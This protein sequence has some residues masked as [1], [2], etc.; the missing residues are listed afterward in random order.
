MLK[1]AYA[2]WEGNRAAVLASSLA[3]LGAVTWL[4]YWTGTDFTFSVFYLIPILLVTW[5]LGLKA[6]A[7]FS[8]LATAAEFCAD[9]VFAHRVYSHPLA[10]Y[11]DTATYLSFFLLIAFAA[12]RVASSN[13]RVADL[14]KLK[15][16]ML[17]LVSH[18]FGN[19]LTVMVG[20]LCLLK[21]AEEDGSP[22]SARR[23]LYQTLDSVCAVLRLTSDTF[24]NQLRMESGSFSLEVR[25]IEV[26]ALAHA[27]VTALSCV[28]ARKQVELVEDFPKQVRAVMADPD[29]LAL[30]FS[31]LVG[32]AIKYTPSGGT[33]TVRMTVPE[34][35]AGRAV[36]AV[37]D[38]G[39][40]IAEQDK[41]AVFSGF[42]RTQEGQRTAKGFGIG[43]RVC[44]DLVERHGSV[45]KLESA[46]GKGSRFTFEVPL[47]PGGD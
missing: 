10:P 32:N 25:R 2:A 43:L 45:L 35:S 28:A 18:E 16:D 31:N 17:S 42:F 21:E 7:I 26:R 5:N 12:S 47:A 22:A 19:N 30:V 6:G 38:T 34:P 14:L 44:K 8:L 37:E 40:G 4:D 1:R 29:A 41:T 46:P 20:T 15:T 27:C 39:I 13:K 11:V 3:I 36:I 33:V 9:D 24:L 23:Q